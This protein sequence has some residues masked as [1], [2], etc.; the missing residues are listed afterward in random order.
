MFSIGKKKQVQE[1]NIKTFKDAVNAIKVFIYIKDWTKAEKAI[2][3]I[4]D[5]EKHAF[6]VLEEKLKDNYSESEKQKK[7]YEKNKKIIDT[8]ASK[9]SLQRKKYE[10]E[11]EEERFKIRFWKIK[12]EIKKLVATGKNNEALNLL[13]HFLED[14]REKPA[15]VTFYDKEKKKILK[16]IEAKKKKDEKKEKYNAE[17]EAL[18]LVGKTVK[19]EESEKKDNKKKGAGILWHIKWKFNFYKNLQ[20]KLKKKQ[21]LDEIKILIEEESKAKE[22]IAQKKLENI[23]KGLVKEL[24]QS[25][26]IGY[27]I[28]W[29]ILWYDKISWDTFGFAESKNKYN[30]FIGDATGHGVRAGLIVSLLSKSFQEN[31]VKENLQ[32]MVLKTNNNLKE[33]LQSRN[34]ATGIFFEIMKDFKGI[35][36][37]VGLGHEPMLVYRT[38][39]RKVEKIIPGGLAGWIRML[40]KAE[41]VQVKNIEMS[42]DDILLTFSDGVVE[43]KDEEG[44]FYGLERLEQTFNHAANAHK[45]INNIYEVIIE[46]LKLFKSGTSFLDDTT[47]LILRRN[48]EKDIV[49]GESVE[50][51]EISEKEWLS[52]TQTKRLEGKNKEEL[53]EELEK[54]RKEKEIENIIKILEWYYLTGEILKLKQE[55]TRFI[56]EG[57]IHKKI[58]Y[59]LKKAIVKENKYRIDQKNTKIQNKYNVLLELYKK[60]DYRTVIQEIN[61]IIAKDWNI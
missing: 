59:Y 8:L 3:E 23:H 26:M 48:E 39:E 34:F 45:N 2:N 14:N 29:K 16:S 58:N 56:K 43:A 11:I 7:K 44:N 19:V 35:V 9:L 60:N 53:E 31:S 49:T 13:T 32:N 27:D 51:R 24:H 15:V 36:S 50:L 54:I 42:H 6:S 25:S 52:R 38:K 40:K 33:N 55:A 4:R 37:F 1:T 30:F 20:E 57:Y 21:L 18:K 10:R 61:E 41:E 46:D 12:Q 22:E 47:M 5:V 17:M 28:Y